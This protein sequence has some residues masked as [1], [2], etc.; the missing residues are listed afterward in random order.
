MTGL[1]VL[2]SIY[3]PSQ[4]GSPVMRQRRVRKYNA[5]SDINIANL[6][7]SCW[8]YYHLY[9]IRTAFTSGMTLTSPKQGGSVDSEAE[10]VVVSIDAKGGIYVN[11]RL[12]SPG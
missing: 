10:G 2:I 6:V 3:R 1:T 4:K 5:Y 8:C 11:E 12:G 9:D 7:M